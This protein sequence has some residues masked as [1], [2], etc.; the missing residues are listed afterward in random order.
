MP[1]EGDDSKPKWQEE[2]VCKMHLVHV[3]P[4]DLFHN[5]KSDL[6]ACRKRHDEGCVTAPS[7]PAPDAPTRIGNPWKSL[8][9][10]PC[11]WHFS[12]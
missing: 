1:K 4:H 5:T 2:N 8:F 7:Q 12:R 11:V 3:C 6:G 9:Y 10:V